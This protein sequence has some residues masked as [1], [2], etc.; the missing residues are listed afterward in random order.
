MKRFILL[1]V[2]SIFIFPACSEHITTNDYKDLKFEDLG[3]NMIYVEGGVFQM[4]K[5]LEVTDDKKDYADEIPADTVTLDSYYIA[6]TE[7]T[8]AQ[9]RAVM[10]NNP[11]YYLGDDRP[12]ESV[13]WKDVQEFCRRLSELTGE[14]FVL[15][16]E[17]QWEY[18]ARGGNNSE[19]YTYSGSDNIDEVAWYSANSHN[20]TLPVGQKLPN[21]L[22]LYDMSGNVWEWC[23]D[24]YGEYG[25]SS[26][27]NPTGPS[28][29]SAR[30]LRGGSWGS[31][32]KHCRV[33]NRDSSE[34]SYSNS[35][36]GFRVVRLLL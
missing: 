24:W 15:P 26:Q 36:I 12:V 16:T 2:I 34:P 33:L 29:G 14:V 21:E 5:V 28:S 20:L 13:S 35:F 4:G 19:G 6:E 32:N 27:T 3:I 7:V 22:G 23:S 31:S 1:Y 18:A 25:S 11:S 10:G 8:Q 9:W 30:V 17:A